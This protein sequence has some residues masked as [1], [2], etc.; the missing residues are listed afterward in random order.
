MKVSARLAALI[1]FMEIIVSRNLCAQYIS[2]FCITPAAPTTSDL[3]KINVHGN[4]ASTGIYLVDSSIIVAGNGAK[5][6]LS[7]IADSGVSLP[8]LLPYSR[9]FHIR[10]LAPGRYSVH[11]QSYFN[12]RAFDS[13]DTAFVVSESSVVEQSSW[14]SGN[15]NGAGLHQNHPNPFNP[16]TIIAFD[17]PRA[18]EVTLKIFDLVGQEVAILANEKMQA[19]RYNFKWEA[20]GLPGGVYFYRL[21][22]EAFTQTRKLLL[23]R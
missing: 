4:L 9:T 10:I 12:G 3:V 17:L 22:T 20:S 11:A 16:S 19:G 2:R 5:I 7:A 13:A 18:S 1:L 15:I 6:F 8:I 23:L 14:E 21:Q